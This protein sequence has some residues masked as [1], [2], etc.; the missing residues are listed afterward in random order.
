MELGLIHGHEL[1]DGKFFASF[2]FAT[3]DA[4]IDVLLR[5]LSG[6]HQN[7]AGYFS[8][9]SDDSDKIQQAVTLLT[10]YIEGSIVALV[11]LLL[12]ETVVLLSDL[13]ES[14]LAE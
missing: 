3:R 5:Q 9:F 4:T 8:E 12:E 2:S 6:I 13:I 1:G 7:M 10:P 11:P 14:V